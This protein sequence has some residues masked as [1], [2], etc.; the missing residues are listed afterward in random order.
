MTDLLL[1]TL[2]TSAISLTI[3]KSHIA[4]SWQSWLK[5]RSTL[6][7]KLST[8]A[9]CVS[10]WVALVLVLMA[11]PQYFDDYVVNLLILVFAVTGASTIVTGGAMRALF[12]HEREVELLRDEVTDLNEYIEVLE[13]SRK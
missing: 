10:H 13:R 3:T 5:T 7:W 8:C 11:A 6:L 9:Y 12:M 4:D 1:L 2:A